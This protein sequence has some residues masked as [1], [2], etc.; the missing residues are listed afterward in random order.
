MENRKRKRR[1]KQWVLSSVESFEID[2]DGLTPSYTAL[3]STMG[4][5][6]LSLYFVEQGLR[7]FLISIQDAH[8][9]LQSDYNRDVAARHIGV[10]AFSCF[11][12]AV[13]GWK[14][15]HLI[16]KEFSAKVPHNRVY[17]YDPQAARIMLYFAA[18]QIKNFFDSLKWNEGPEFLMHHV[19][20]AGSSLG[21]LVPHPTFHFYAIFYM[22]ISEFSTAVLSL[23]A[24]FDD[25]HGA[26]GL[27][28]AF[29][30]VKAILGGFFVVL[31]ISIRVFAW[32]IL[33]YRYFSD[34]WT[35]QR[36][37]NDIDYQRRNTFIRWNSVSLGL[38][39]LLQIV[40]LFE[41][42]KVC[43]LEMAKLGML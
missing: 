23:L 21:G 13:F 28:D 4:V 22:G 38:V 27:G 18:F 39:T 36:H 29:P 19:L 25:V 16:Y 42:L 7:Q 2:E 32:S 24:N 5:V 35:I 12:V 1:K 33:T 11:V 30:L 17:L 20:A 43:Q 34:V 9:V 10:N 15:R 31:F 3:V 26:K 8:P 41:V 6:I 40:W 14:A 37:R